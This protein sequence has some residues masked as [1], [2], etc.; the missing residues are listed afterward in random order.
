MAEYYRV[1][2]PFTGPNNERFLPGRVV[3][4]SD[5]RNAPKLAAQGRLLPCSPP[6]SLVNEKEGKHAQS[7]HQG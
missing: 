6:E 5:W 7:R 3:D 1:L 2:R 4:G